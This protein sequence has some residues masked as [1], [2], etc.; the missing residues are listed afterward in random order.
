MLNKIR[1]CQPV[2]DFLRSR[3]L[4]FLEKQTRQTNQQF[5]MDNIIY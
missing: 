4:N 1:Q 3:F 5:T 2:A